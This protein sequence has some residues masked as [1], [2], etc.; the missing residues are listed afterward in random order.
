[1]KRIAAPMVGGLVT[2]FALELLVYPAVYILWKERELR[3]EFP[4]SLAFEWRYSSGELTTCAPADCCAQ[5]GIPG[6]SMWSQSGR[7]R[8]SVCSTSSEPHRPGRGRR[9]SPWDRY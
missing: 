1:M 7:P 5:I 8:G 9:T 2:S 3:E 4:A 6:R